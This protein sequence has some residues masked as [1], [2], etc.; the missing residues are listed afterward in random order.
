MMVE[1]EKSHD[2]LSTIS[3]CRKANDL[4]ARKR[5]EDWCPISAVRQ[6]ERILPSS[7]FLFSL[8]LE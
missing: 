5:V 2:L 1:Y 7:T 6:K 8:G 3:R 4:S